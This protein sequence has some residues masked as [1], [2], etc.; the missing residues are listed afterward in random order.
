[1]K[2]RTIVMSDLH[3]G[4]KASR[5]K[6]IIKFLENNTCET[7]IL[8]G[9]II[10]GWALK[11]GSS[12]KDEHTKVLRKILKMSEKGTKVI[13]LRGN[14]DEFLEPYLNTILGNI[15]IQEDMVYN[16]FDGKSYY[17]FHGDILDVFSSKFKLIAKIGSVGYDLALWLNRWYNKYREWRKLPYYSISNDIKRE[18]KA[19]VNFITDFENRAIEFAKKKNCDSAICGHIHQVEIRENYM[20]SGDWCENCTALVESEEKGWEVF[21]FHK[22]V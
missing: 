21:Y 6:D 1:M 8:N 5:A 17:I 10:D 22:Q 11:R 7:L 3:L 13:W 2:Y 12:W 20:N 19:A 4:S 14:H 16:G 15:T 18:V 9:D